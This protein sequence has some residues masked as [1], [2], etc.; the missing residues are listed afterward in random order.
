[1]TAVNIPAN[2]LKN[3]DLNPTEKLVF[4]R[5]NSFAPESCYMKTKDFSEELGISLSCATQCLSKLKKQHLVVTKKYG[6]LV[7]VEGE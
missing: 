6:G 4:G 2:I 5:I 7:A 3:T 1:M